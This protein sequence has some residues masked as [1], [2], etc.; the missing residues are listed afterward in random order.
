MNSTHVL[1]SLAVTVVCIAAATVARADPTLTTLVS[2]NGAD[3]AGPLGSLVADGNGNLYGT[4]RNG[5]AYGY[6]TVFELSGP[7]H[8]TLTT[9]VSF[10]KSNGAYPAGGPYPGGGGG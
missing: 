10:N 8:Q 3:G 7:G 2:F 4:T 5:G 9:L 6:G 1:R